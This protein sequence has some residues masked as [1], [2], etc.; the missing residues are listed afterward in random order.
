MLQNMTSASNSN[1]IADT[2]S[3]R[4]LSMNGRTGAA[5]RRRLAPAP[6]GPRPA[7]DK[8]GPAT[9]ATRMLG[10]SQRTKQRRTIVAIAPQPAIFSDDERIAAVVRS[11]RTKLICFAEIDESEV[12][13][14]V[15]CNQKFNKA[16]DKTGGPD[17]VGALLKLASYGGADGKF[18]SRSE[19][20][21]FQAEVTL[22][23]DTFSA[24]NLNYTVLFSLF[25]TMYVTLL[26]LHVGSNAYSAPLPNSLSVEGQPTGVWTD[27]ATFCWPNDVPAQVSLRPPMR[28]PSLGEPAWHRRQAVIAAARAE[29]T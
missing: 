25:M 26:V 19:L 15:S 20:Q 2:S 5:P 4:F 8:K 1:D 3:P 14:C 18:L 7:P 17:S 28:R 11:A 21:R 9:R 12:Y 24:T 29:W 10:Q 16:V 27:L 22:L 13:K 23:I 6:D